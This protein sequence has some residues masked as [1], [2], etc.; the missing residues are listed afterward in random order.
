MIQENIFVFMIHDTFLIDIDFIKFAFF[1]NIDLF[2]IDNN[3]I[4]IRR[5]MSLLIFRFLE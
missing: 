4:M 1:N 3:I 5:K 2:P